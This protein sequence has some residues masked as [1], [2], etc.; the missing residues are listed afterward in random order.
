[1]GLTKPRRGELVLK[2]NQNKNRVLKKNFLQGLYHKLFCLKPI[3]ESIT[4]TQYPFV[5]EI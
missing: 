1:M 4:H 2:S 3:I 5:K